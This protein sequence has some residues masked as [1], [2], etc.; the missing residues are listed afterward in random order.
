MKLLSAD[1]FLYV[2]EESS[3]VLWIPSKVPSCNC[4]PNLVVSRL[5][6]ILVYV[7]PECVVI[8]GL[9]FDTG[10]ERGDPCSCSE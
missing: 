9:D 8:S 7:V 10:H 1:V 6:G 4:A 3:E 5:S 2:I